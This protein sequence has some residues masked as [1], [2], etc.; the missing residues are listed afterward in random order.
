[1]NQS[2]T[3]REH[4]ENRA[5]CRRFLVTDSAGDQDVPATNHVSPRRIWW[6]RRQHFESEILA[7]RATTVAGVVAKANI[8]QMWGGLDTVPEDPIDLRV[9]YNI[10]SDLIVM[11]AYNVVSQRQF[12][13]A[14]RKVGGLPLH[15]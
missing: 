6:H 9:V 14:S 13:P 7:M 15:V 5:C 11:S 4:G 8:A 10:A 3:C 2:R 1:L 12:R